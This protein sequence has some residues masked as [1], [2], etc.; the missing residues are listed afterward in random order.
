MKPGRITSR[1]TTSIKG[2]SDIEDVFL[3]EGLIPV[4]ILREPSKLPSLEQY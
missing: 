4:D 1:A 2:P 3:L